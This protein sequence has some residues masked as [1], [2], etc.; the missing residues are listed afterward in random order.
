MNVRAGGF[1]KSH[2]VDIPTDIASI[3]NL[4]PCKIM[5]RLCSLG[6]ACHRIESNRKGSVRSGSEQTSKFS[7]SCS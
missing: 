3:V 6:V 1:V 2:D 5:T 7:V 4:C